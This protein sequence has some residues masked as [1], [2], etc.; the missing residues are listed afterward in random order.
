MI[1]MCF[2]GIE[3]EKAKAGE[4]RRDKSE[5]NESIKR[6][7]PADTHTDYDNR[8]QNSKAAKNERRMM[9]GS[10]N[11]EESSPAKSRERSMFLWAKD[12][13]RMQIQLMFKWHVDY[14]YW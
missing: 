6:D 12:S 13:C 7:T 3:H 10:E 9:K 8:S 1:V 14:D 11:E 4:M 5:R 2:F